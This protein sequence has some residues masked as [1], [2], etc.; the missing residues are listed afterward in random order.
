MFKSEPQIR[1]GSTKVPQTS[2]TVVL[3]I[4]SFRIYSLDIFA[5]SETQVNWGICVPPGFLRLTSDVTDHSHPFIYCVVLLCLY[6]IPFG[7]FPVSSS[8]VHGL[9]TLL[10]CFFVFSQNENM[11]NWAMLFLFNTIWGLKSFVYFIMHVW[12][13]KCCSCRTGIH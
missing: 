7:K 8:I 10:V 4:I 6:I 9:E 13:T 12:M 1:F 3:T 2:V 5:H 11:G